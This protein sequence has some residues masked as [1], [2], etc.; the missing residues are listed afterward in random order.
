MGG[1]ELALRRSCALGLLAAYGHVT[2]PI[3]L[4][5]AY[6]VAN[7]LAAVPLTPGGLGIVEAVAATSLIGFGVPAAIAWLG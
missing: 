5:V 3:D 6:G 2:R 7:V 4:F 1:R